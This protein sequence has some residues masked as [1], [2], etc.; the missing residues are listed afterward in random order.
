MAR[1]GPIFWT[2]VDGMNHLAMLA[3]ASDRVQNLP[4]LSQ[5]DTRVINTDSPPAVDDGRAA[6]RALRRIPMTS[7][8]PLVSVIIPCYNQGHFLSESLVSA[9]QQTYARVEIVAVNDGS[10]DSTAAVLSSFGDSIRSIHKQNGGLSSARN[11]GLAIAQGELIL[12]LDSDDAINPEFVAL[13]VAALDH[14]PVALTIGRGIQF[15]GP[16]AQAQ[17]RR[18]PTVPR[19]P[20][21][22]E[23]AGDH[24]RH[25]ERPEPGAE[26]PLI[27]WLRAGGFPVHSAL[28]RRTWLPEPAP[29][30]ESLKSHEDYDLW[31]RLV[32]RHATTVSVPGAIAYYRQHGESLSRNRDRMLTTRAIVDL[33]YLGPVMADPALREQAAS[34][35]ASDLAS[36][37][38]QLTLLGQ[39]VPS[40]RKA[41]T[42]RLWNERLQLA[43]AGFPARNHPLVRVAESL[44][45]RDADGWIAGCVRWLPRRMRRRLG[46]PD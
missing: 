46:S 33:R 2:G 7:T 23:T 34:F 22:A 28:V 13:S 45:G 19:R 5:H 18:P 24:R 20:S 38:R 17:P 44:W 1:R 31:W 35:L 12:F 26:R 32:L 37:R 4:T 42:E 25:D 27:E 9:L 21:A 43:A 16:L 10:T 30:D 39:P 14:H 36:L 3:A 6:K 8:Q 11:A 41:L 40:D 15:S 29:F